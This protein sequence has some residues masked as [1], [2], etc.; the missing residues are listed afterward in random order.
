[1]KIKKHCAYFHFTSVKIQLHKQNIYCSGFLL[2]DL[3]CG[4]R[5][6]NKYRKWKLK[7]KINSTIH[8]VINYY[9]FHYRLS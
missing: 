1:M 9:G 7:S 4:T 6:I 5:Y 3:S 2:A 8:K